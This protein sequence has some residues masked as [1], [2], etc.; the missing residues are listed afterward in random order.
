MNKSKV[1]LYILYIIVAIV[2]L[3]IASCAN[4]DLVGNGDA[5][6]GQPMTLGVD[7]VQV[8]SGTRAQSLAPA[9]KNYQM[10]TTT[11]K[12]IY[13][14]MSSEA[15]VG[16]HD[17]DNLS[18]NNNGAMADATRGVS[19]TSDTFY[20]K[21]GL[22]YYEYDKGDTWASIVATGTQKPVQATVE[23]SA[24]WH[25]NK[26]WP[27]ID[28]K[29]TFMAYA[30]LAA[31]YKNASGTS[32]IQF[33][34]NITGYPTLTYTVPDKVEDQQDL[35][36]SAE[37]GTQD[38]E[39]DYNKVIGMKFYH[40][41]SAINFKI[42]STMA[43]GLISK[44][45][46]KGI[47]N[48]G[49][50]DFGTKVWTNQSG[51]ANYSIAPNY[52][53]GTDRGVVFTGVEDSKNDLFLVMPQ[54][55]PS[56]AKIVV[57]IEGQEMELPINSHEW[58]PGY[59]ITYTLSTSQ[60]EGD[61]IFSV[62]K[63]ND[64]STEK[65]ST[66]SYKVSSYMQSYYGSQTPVGWKAKYAVDDQITNDEYSEEYGDVVQGGFVFDMSSPLSST[67]SLS[68]S[69]ASLEPPVSDAGRNTHT[70]NL[71]AKSALGTKENPYDLSTLGGTRSMSTANCYVI[72]APGWYKFPLVYG[73]CIKN[74][75]NNTAVYGTD[76]KF[77]SFLNHL[78]QQISAPWLVE[79]DGVNPSDAIVLWQDAYKM[80]V[81]DS[82]DISTDKKYLYFKVNKDNICQGNALLAVRDASQTIL[83]SWH[84]WVTD[85]NLSK[86][87]PVT[88]Q[89]GSVYDFMTVP[90]G[91]CEPD[92]RTYKT[93]KVKFCFEQEESNMLVEVSFGQ[94]S[95]SILE[96]GVNAP[97][98]QFGKNTP[99][100]LGTGM[101]NAFKTLYM[102]TGYSFSV[103][104]AYSTRGNAI[105]NPL[106]HYYSSPG[107]WNTKRRLTDV[108]DVN[109]T[110][111]TVYDKS[112]NPSLKS[113][114]DP[115]PVGYK[116]PE[117]AAYTGFTKSGS[118]TSSTSE[119]N[120]SGSFNKGWT[121]YTK[122]NKQGGTIFFHSLNLISWEAASFYKGFNSTVIYLTSGPHSNTGNDQGRSLCCYTTNVNPSSEWR[123]CYEMP[124][125]PVIDD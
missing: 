94:S 40:T 124:I 86:S 101:S 109:N 1:Y 83:W 29:L 107:D 85:E 14:Q 80:I 10:K 17:A 122:P 53:I 52:Q 24:G 56:G 121:F 102:A 99:M 33:P 46:I 68:A 73:N 119:F 93:R 47:H 34:T 72:G 70:A 39:G 100:H 92:K 116:V 41:L 12:P 78:N 114:Y 98:Y 90:L 54:T 20:D 28:H 18:E 48:K 58:L 108:W 15:Y 63:I 123:R 38:M 104:N 30:P 42:G 31:D 9:I 55:V 111:A 59:T 61:Y 106:V 44:I 64:V 37:P 113:I 117:P 19:V 96:Y 84:I 75:A 112:T 43:P 67:S 57:T 62:S 76:T 110:G 95:T 36:V 74:G 25:T 21:F 115:C 118:S 4:D 5:Q 7:V 6:N 50:Y 35:L 91:F 88:N 125:R 89:K 60:E 120:V 103:K 66:V 77:S 69:L 105:Q 97:Y 51:T 49:S 3:A 71:R 87:I 27:G 79:N 2:A 82:I 8:N 65:A 22:F 23:K 32:Y 11:D 26:Y 16:K 45:E 81:P 13:V